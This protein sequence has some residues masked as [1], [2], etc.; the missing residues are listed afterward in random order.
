MC[1]KL[2]RLEKNLRQFLCPIILHLETRENKV[3]NEN[4][5]KNCVTYFC[6]WNFCVNYFAA[7]KIMKNKNC[8]EIFRIF[9]FFD[10]ISNLCPVI[11]SSFN[12][13]FLSFENFNFL[14]SAQ[15]NLSLS[16]FPYKSIEQFSSPFVF[17]TENSNFSFGY[18]KRFL[19]K[20]KKLQSRSYYFAI[21]RY[22]NEFFYISEI[23][24]N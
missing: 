9:F 21:D 6:I 18:F 17:L 8:V 13:F 5:K 10:H 12:V 20:E 7:S 23:Y 3:E 2:I 16:F 1:L 4:A 11:H 22:L 14:S 15:R 24:V 19:E